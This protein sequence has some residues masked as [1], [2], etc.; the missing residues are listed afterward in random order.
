VLTMGVEE[1]FLL[2]AQDGSVSPVASRVVQLAGLPEQIK[3]EFM[4]YQVETATTVC[5]RLDE[6]RRDLVRLRLIAADTAERCGAILVASGSLPLT[7]ESPRLPADSSRYHELARRFPD[8]TASGATCACHVH[9]GIPN[10]EL[11]VAVLAR[12]RPW[13]PALLAL[14]VNSPFAGGQDTGWASYRYHTQLRWPTFRPP[15]AWPSAER[16]DGVVRSLILAGAAMDTASVY[17]LAR[18]SARYPTIEVRVADTCL[19]VEDTV[20]YAG[21]VRALVASVIDDVRNRE[22]ALPAPTGLLDA[23]LLAAAHGQ[24]RIRLGRPAGPGDVVA[25]LLARIAPYVATTDPADDVFTGLDRIRRDGAG[26][27]RQR[28][29]WTGRPA[30]FIHSLAEA[31]VPVAAVH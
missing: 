20:L 26:A 18:L 2:L 27:D 28:R 31:T 12:I 24:L 5:T 7:V 8:A 30:E 22:K 16:Y 13:L 23:Q 9:I 17:F 25:R 3:P 1:E 19:D 21:V 15:G 10:R 11:A 4:A 6:L 29:L 14:T